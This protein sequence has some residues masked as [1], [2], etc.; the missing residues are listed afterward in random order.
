MNYNPATE[1]DRPQTAK[2]L[3]QS[4]GVW[5]AT[6]HYNFEDYPERDAPMYDHVLLALSRPDFTPGVNGRTMLVAYA[7]HKSLSTGRM[8]TA[9]RVRIAGYR[10][11]YQLCQLVARISRDCPE[12]TIGGI[13][14]RWIAEHHRD[15]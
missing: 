5:P 9:S 15:L 6:R 8:P 10:R 3:A 12:T 7:L 1:H 11:P 4:I 14:D 13:C 2:E